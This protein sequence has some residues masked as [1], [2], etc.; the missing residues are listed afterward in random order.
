MHRRYEFLYTT[1]EGLLPRRIVDED[2]CDPEIEPLTVGY[3]R[4][5]DYLYFIQENPAAELL[6]LEIPALYHEFDRQLRVI[7]HQNSFAVLMDSGILHGNYGYEKHYKY[8]NYRQ[9]HHRIEFPTREHLIFADDKSG[10]KYNRI[11]KKLVAKKRRY[12]GKEIIREELQ[13]DRL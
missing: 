1:E 9:K 13:N 10:R 4:V 6:S 5:S 11:S 8:Y 3:F 12:I 7:I 2:V